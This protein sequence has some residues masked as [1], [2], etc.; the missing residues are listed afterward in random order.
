MSKSDLHDQEMGVPQGSI[1]SDT[2]FNTK[3]NNSVNALTPGT[4]CP[5]YVDDFLICYHSLSMASIELQLQHNIN[6]IQ[7][8]ATNNG[9]KVSKTKIK[10]TQFINLLI[11]SVLFPILIGV[12]IQPFY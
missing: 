8:W 5:L 4:D 2:L 10:C 9:F 12:Q 3:I 6:N 11:Y 1:L 7:H